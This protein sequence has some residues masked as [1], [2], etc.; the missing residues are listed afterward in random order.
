M[1]S[2]AVGLEQIREATP[3]FKAR[4]AAVFSLL[5]ILASDRRRLRS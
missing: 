1:M 5:T 3:R 4:M 2:T